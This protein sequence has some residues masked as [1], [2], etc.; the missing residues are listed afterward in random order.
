MG[1]SLSK[2]LDPMIALEAAT[3][4]VLNIQP[5]EICLPTF[6]NIATKHA[7]CG[8]WELQSH[9]F[10]D[11]SSQYINVLDETSLFTAMQEWDFC[12]NAQ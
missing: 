12:V 1:P 6:S 7:N 3:L 11:N 5:T 4:P 2:I 10:G 9:M 8:Q